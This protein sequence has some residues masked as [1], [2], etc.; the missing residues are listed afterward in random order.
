MGPVDFDGIDP[1]LSGP[2]GGGSKIIYDLL[3]LLQGHLFW[4]VQ[5]RFPGNGRG[6]QGW[7]SGDFW[8][9]QPSRMMELKGHG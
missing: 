1:R 5:S 9:R 3:D 6:G 4:R 2:A 7:P 8:V